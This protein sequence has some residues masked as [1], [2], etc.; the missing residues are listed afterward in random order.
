VTKLKSKG[1]KFGRT[2][3]KNVSQESSHKILN[4]R[5]LNRRFSQKGRIGQHG[6]NQR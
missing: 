2:W 4:V 5:I 6:Y 1:S 3:F